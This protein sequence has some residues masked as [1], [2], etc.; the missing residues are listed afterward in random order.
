MAPSIKFLGLF[1]AI[2]ELQYGCHIEFDIVKNF[3]VVSQLYESRSS[4]SRGGLPFSWTFAGVQC[5]LSNSKEIFPSGL[6]AHFLLEN[7]G[8]RL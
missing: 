4:R 5:S 6:K 1:V 7:M 2:H 3:G 8:L